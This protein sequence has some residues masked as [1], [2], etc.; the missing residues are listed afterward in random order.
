[1]KKVF[2]I[3]LCAVMILAAAVPA[4]AVVR[5]IMAA[6][7]VDGKLNIVVDGGLEKIEAL[8]GDTVDVTIQF[9]KNTTISSAKI[10][11]TYNKKLSVVTV[12]DKDNNVIPKVTFDIDT[13]Q[14]DGSEQT[15]ATLYAD[16]NQLLLNWLTALGEVK[17]DVVYATV[18]FKVADNAKVGDFLEI[19]ATAD[20][21][22]IYDKDVKNTAFAIINGGV[23]VVSE[24][25][26]TESE[27]EEPGTEPEESGSETEE[28]GTEPEESGSEPESSEKESEDDESTDEPSEVLKGDC[29]GNGEVNNKDVVTLFRYVSG[30]EKVEDESAYDFNGDGEV[31]NKDVVELFRYVSQ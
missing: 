23:T 9:K 5:N 16:K 12:K 21:E 28:P 18:T 26:E 3:I 2:G 30:D 29:D 1:M 8:A 14:T 17:G 19:T 13:K 27:T 25:V 10:L 22:D 4:Y 6:D 24:P 31:N 20:A 7:L 15:W 11:L